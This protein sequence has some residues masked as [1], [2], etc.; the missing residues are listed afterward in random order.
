MN[1]SIL[2]AELPG[3]TYESIDKDTATEL[4]KNPA[5]GARRAIELKN[6]GR[7][8][9][10][11]QVQ[12]SPQGDVL[13]WTLVANANDVTALV[14]AIIPEAVKEAASEQSILA[15]FATLAIRASVPV[16]EQ[17][18]VL[19]FR[20]NDLA[21]FRI[22]RVQPGAAAMLTDGPKD[23]IEAVE[24]P[25]LLVSIAAAGTPPPP[26]ERDSF[27]RRMIGEMPGMKDMRVLRSEPMRIA[28]Q[29]GYEV[30]IEAK[31]MKTGTDLNAVQ[32]VRFGSGTLMRIFA[33]SRKDTW[34]DMFDRFRKVRDGI[35][36]R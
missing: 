9:V 19:P 27:A 36:P 11:K 31:D 21:G 6:G 12:P 28:N 1:A 2:V 20:M 17:L 35:G 16:D 26:A 7:G 33:V 10:V 30:L 3:Y 8:F 24:Q 29:Q 32:W 22:V 18:S 5:V 34:H 14:T 15:A 23:A 13:K 25:L 4:Q